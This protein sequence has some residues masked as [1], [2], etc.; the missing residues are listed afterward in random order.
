V[1]LPP[2]PGSTQAVEMGCTCPVIDNGRGKGHMKDKNGYILF[3]ITEGCPLHTDTP[4][5][6]VKGN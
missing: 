1:I 6:I 3:I 4:L 2:P 5:P